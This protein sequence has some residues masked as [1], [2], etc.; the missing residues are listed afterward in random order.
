MR[1]A[2][3]LAVVME[4]SCSLSSLWLGAA[5][6]AQCFRNLSS[7]V[8]LALLSFQLMLL[9]PIVV[10]TRGCALVGEVVLGTGLVA[11]VI[12][13]VPAFS[14]TVVCKLWMCYLNS[15]S[16]ATPGCGKSVF[17]RFAVSKVLI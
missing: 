2:I 5:T 7:C 16:A 10:F 4:S 9:A 8:G 11:V 14:A 13:C 6:T 12:F 3:E 17:V 15:T 1:N